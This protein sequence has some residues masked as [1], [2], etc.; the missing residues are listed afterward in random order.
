MKNKIIYNNIEFDS[1]GEEF[2]Y[3]YLN[4]LKEAKYVD[5]FIYQPETF[6][7]SEKI[8]YPYDIKKSKIVNGTLLNA[9]EYTCDFKIYWNI[10]ALNVFYLNVDNKKPLNKIPFIAQNNISYCEC[11]PYWDQNNMTREARINIKWVYKQFGILVQI[12]IPTAPNKKCLFAKTFVPFSENVRYT[13][14]TKKQ[15]IFK[16]TVKSLQEYVNGIPRA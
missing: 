2:F 5:D 13:R 4:E 7:L 11:K 1:E 16:Y 14:K 9:H 6:K 12:I 8:L 15:K 10:S 3:H